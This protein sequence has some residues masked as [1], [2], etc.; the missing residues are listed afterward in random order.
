MRDWEG[1]HKQYREIKKWENSLEIK[2]TVQTVQRAKFM[3]CIFYCN[4]KK[5]KL[6]ATVCINHLTEQGH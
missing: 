6:D 3:F 1:N 2:M 4:L 5:K